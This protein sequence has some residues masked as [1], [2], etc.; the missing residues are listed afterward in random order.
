MYDSA[1]IIAMLQFIM[2]KLCEIEQDLQDLRNE[3][4]Q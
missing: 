2:K 1:T 4:A 3:N